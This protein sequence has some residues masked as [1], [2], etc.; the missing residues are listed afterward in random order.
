MGHGTTFYECSKQTQTPLKQTKLNAVHLYCILI[1]Q[2]I[3][4]L[5]V[6]VGLYAN[7]SEGHTTVVAILFTSISKYCCY[8]DT[9]VAQL[10]ILTQ[11]TTQQ[12]SI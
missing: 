1:T 10:H 12:V 9:I 3:F 8:S 11:L 7:V 5:F 6:I 4:L 2:G